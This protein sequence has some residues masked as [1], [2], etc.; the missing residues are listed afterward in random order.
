MKIKNIVFGTMIALGSLVATGASASCS[1]TGKVERVYTAGSYAYVY[2][3]AITGLASS[4]YYYF[5]TPDDTLIAAAEA[6]KAD[7]NAYVNV[8]GDASAC[9][10]TGT[11]RYGGAISSITRY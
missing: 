10:T 8:I 6:A 2:L 7:G 4:A 9:P 11:A 1:F 3:E 5:Y